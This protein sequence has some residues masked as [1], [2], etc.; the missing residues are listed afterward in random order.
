[1]KNCIFC[2]LISKEI[3]CYKIYEDK[4]IY[5]FLDI[6][7]VNIGHTLVIPKK[8]YNTL[9]DCDDETLCKLIK[10]VKKISKAVYKSMNAEGFNIGVNTGKVAGAGYKDHLH[11]H[12][13]PRWKEDTNF[14]PVVFNTKVV[15][16]SLNE[17]YGELHKR[18]RK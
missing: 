12:I 2:K 17:L 16:Q 9:L 4:D 7:P 5:A 8:H 14:M 18:I 6:S 15:S 1:M 3:P 11:I 13:V 10:A